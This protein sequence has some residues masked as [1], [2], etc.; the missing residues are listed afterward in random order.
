[1]PFFFYNN[2]CVAS[3]VLYVSWEENTVNLSF[4]LTASSLV[5]PRFSPTQ[6]DEKKFAFNKTYFLPVVSYTYDDN[7]N[8]GNESLINYISFA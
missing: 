8:N 3:V 7:N 4:S 6:T 1:M 2:T 5:H